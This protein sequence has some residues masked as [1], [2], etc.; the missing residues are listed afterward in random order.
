M[1]YYQ[2]LRLFLYHLKFNLDFDS[3]RQI[4]NTAFKR[5]YHRLAY[6]QSKLTDLT[7]RQK[8]LVAERQSRLG[9]G[10]QLQCRIVW[11]QILILLAPKSSFVQFSVSYLLKSI[12]CILDNLIVSFR[13]PFPFSSCYLK[14]LSCAQNGLTKLQRP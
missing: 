5:H 2:K 8:Q 13:Y 11:V 1:G 4:R 12:N 6:E 9:V 10:N 7:A 14:C 3:T